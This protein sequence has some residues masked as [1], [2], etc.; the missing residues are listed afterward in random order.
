MIQLQLYMCSNLSWAGGSNTTIVI[1]EIFAACCLWPLEW[2][3]LWRSTWTGRRTCWREASVAFILGPGKTT[4]ASLRPC[5]CAFQML[6][7][8]WTGWKCQER[9]PSC[10]SRKT[11][12]W[13]LG[14]TTRC[15]R[16]KDARSLWRRP[17][18]WRHTPRRER[19]YRPCCWTSTSTRNSTQPSEPLLQ[20]GSVAEKTASS[21]GPSR[22]FSSTEACPKGP[23]SCW[24]PCV[25]RSWIGRLSERAV[26][27][28]RLAADAWSSYP[29][30][31]STTT[32]GN[33]FVP[34][35]VQ[36]A[37]AAKR[38]LAIMGPSVGRS[39]VAARN[40]FVMDA[41]SP[42]WRM[43]SHVPNSSRMRQRPSRSSAS[44]AAG[45]EH[46]TFNAA[47]ARPLLPCRASSGQTWP[48]CQ[49]HGSL[50]RR[51]K[52]RR[53]RRLRD[54]GNIRDGSSAVAVVRCSQ[55][56]PSH[57]RSTTSKAGAVWIATA[58][59]HGRMTSKLAEA[60][61]ASGPRYNPRMAAPASATAPPA[62]SDNVE[63]VPNED[64]FATTSHGAWRVRE[65]SRC[66]LCFLTSR[67]RVYSYLL[68]QKKRPLKHGGDMLVTS[69]SECCLATQNPAVYVTQS[70]TCIF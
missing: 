38:F 19:P 55:P 27:L 56:H 4:T 32:S 60:A 23:G 12:S 44:N 3:W 70:C 17:T 26:F 11:G 50:V 49:P 57:A 63:M 45:A 31:P 52:T 7:G 30:M 66:R 65:Q 43:P 28:R 46:I 33:E 18:P 15:W 22:I 54:P 68:C 2:R 42:K 35:I 34:M 59:A 10:P 9:T 67:S 51:A 58:V 21:Y 6:N 1:P 36:N 69:R 48:P 24:R 8:S 16:S 53:S 64:I 25:G 61:S 37:S 20:A 29:S 62:E 47:S 13:M 40:I 5:T 39:T 41:R 14:E